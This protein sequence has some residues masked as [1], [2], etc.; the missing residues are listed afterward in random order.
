MIL[1][2]HLILITLITA[3]IKL[4][5]EGKMICGGTQFSSAYA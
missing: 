2:K 5:N 4:A 1:M 3:G